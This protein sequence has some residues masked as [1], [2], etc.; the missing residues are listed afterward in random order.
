MPWYRQRVHYL[1]IEFLPPENKKNNTRN[2][3]E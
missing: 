3:P 2:K 1:L